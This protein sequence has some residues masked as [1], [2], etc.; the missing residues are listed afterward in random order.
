[1]HEWHIY[2]CTYMHILIQVFVCAIQR[3][4]NWLHDFSLNFCT[5]VFCCAFGCTNRSDSERSFHAFLKH[6]ILCQ[7]WLHQVN[8]DHFV[9][10]KHS[11][12]CSDHFNPKLISLR[13]GNQFILQPGVV[14]T[15]FSHRKR[16][17]ER[18][19]TAIHKRNTSGRNQHCI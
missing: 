15:V 19:V 17:P 9:P 4:L 1:M 12:L 13:R 6:L 3:P 8:R 16:I 14:P 11:C 7:K 5:M 2:L 10:S 18:P